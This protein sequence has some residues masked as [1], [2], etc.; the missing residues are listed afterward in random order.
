MS[1]PAD[2]STYRVHI[3]ESG[4]SYL[5]PPQRSVL[6][7]MEALRR[8]GIAVG[9]RNGGCGVCKVRVTSGQYHTGKMSRAVCTQAEQAAGL[10]LACRLY[11]LSDLELSVVGKMARALLA[12]AIAKNAPP[13]FGLT[14][15]API[16]PPDEE[17]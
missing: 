7:G 1:S 11:P 5:C 6:H 8:K 16:F 15:T 10:A 12:P 17:T 3:A 13:S 2:S 14:A 9:C 4:E